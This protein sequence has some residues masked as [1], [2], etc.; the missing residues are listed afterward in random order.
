MKNMARYGKVCQ[1]R[2]RYDNVRKNSLNFFEN[3]ICSGLSIREN[4]C[5]GFKLPH[6]TDASSRHTPLRTNCRVYSS[7]FHFCCLIRRKHFKTPLQLSQRQPSE[8]VASVSWISQARMGDLPTHSATPVHSPPPAPANTVL[9]SFVSI[10][11]GARLL[12]F[13]LGVSTGRYLP[14]ATCPATRQAASS[15]QMRLPRSPGLAA[16]LHLSNLRA[17]SY[18][19]N[20]NTDN[21]NISDDLQR[22]SKCFRRFHGT[23]AAGKAERSV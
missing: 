14:L 15:G 6:L 13:G 2:A 12:C 10:T 5:N 3:L 17:L 8:L 11:R 18:G 21:N 19:N 7:I 9:S 22:F 23:V 20:N 1:G 16:L 4:P